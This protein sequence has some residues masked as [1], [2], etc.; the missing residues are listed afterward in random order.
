MNVNQTMDDDIY[1]DK[2]CFTD[3]DCPE[4]NTKALN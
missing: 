1:P 3:M 2:I 4:K